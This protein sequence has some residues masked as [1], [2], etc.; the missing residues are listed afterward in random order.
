MKIIEINDSNFDEEVLM[1][2]IP[3]LVDMSAVWCGPCKKQLPILEACATDNAGKVKIVKVDIDDS[4]TIA[5]R[6]GI[7]SVPS[8]ILFNLGKQVD[9]KVGLTSASSL[10]IFLEKVGI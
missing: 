6:F 10:D 5:S 7:R 9:M 2:P 3:V 1:S 4:P 8:L